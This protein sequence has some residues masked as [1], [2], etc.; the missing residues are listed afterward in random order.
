MFFRSGIATAC[1][2]DVVKPTWI[3]YAITDMEFWVTRCSKG[4]YR[5][6]IM[7]A[8]IIIVIIINNLFYSICHHNDAAGVFSERV[9]I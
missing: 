3:I 6:I 7:S 9:A 8:K 2:S 4:T 5:A 1:E